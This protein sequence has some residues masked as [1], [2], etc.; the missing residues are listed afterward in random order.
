MS[1]EFTNLSTLSE[2]A[3]QACNPRAQEAK[4]GGSFDQRQD[5]KV[6]FS[7]TQNKEIGKY[8]QVNLGLNEY[9]FNLK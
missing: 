2:V 3:A 9:S 4:S 8:S 1:S 7:K 5:S 6:L